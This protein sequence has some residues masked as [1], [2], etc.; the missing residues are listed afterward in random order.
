MQ[1]K[2]IRKITKRSSSPLKERYAQETEMLEG[3]M[4]DKIQTQ[5]SKKS[6]DYSRG[7]RSPEFMQRQK[8][9]VNKEYDNSEMKILDSQ[10]TP[11]LDNETAEERELI[12]Q[13]MGEEE[14]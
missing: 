5:P 10:N 3:E 11:I 1:K 7:S 12:D 6:N 14:D 2:L 4:N 8:T 9:R 13:V